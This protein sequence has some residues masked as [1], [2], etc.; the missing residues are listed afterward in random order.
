MLMSVRPQLSAS[1]VVCGG[2]LCGGGLTAVIR[3]KVQDSIGAYD[4]DAR[5]LQQARFGS[6]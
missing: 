2:G 4:V 1:G 6:Q 3:E 5:R